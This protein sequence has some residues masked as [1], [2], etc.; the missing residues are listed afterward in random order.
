MGKENLLFRPGRASGE[1]IIET[2]D[3]QLLKPMEF[4]CGVAYLPYKF[5]DSGL[6]YL[7]KEYN[8]PIEIYE[9]SDF[10]NGR[11]I[12]SQMEVEGY[13]KTKESYFKSE[14]HLVISTI[15]NAE[16][17]SG[18][19]IRL[20]NGKN[21]EEL[22]DVLTFTRPVKKASLLDLKEQ[23]IQELSVSDNKV[24]LENIGHCKFVTVYVE[25]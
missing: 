1:R 20:Y 8:T 18:I 12:F 3:A 14:N 22:S 23:E 7:A 19:I 4:T 6:E 5:N 17:K 25:L 13:N 21:H 24:V 9:Y 10:L 15:K 11:L 2:P 16:E